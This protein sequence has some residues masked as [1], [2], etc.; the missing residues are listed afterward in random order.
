VVGKIHAVDE[1][2]LG[3]Q[4]IYIRSGNWIYCFSMDIGELYTAELGEIFGEPENSDHEEAE[5]A[6]GIQAHLGADAN[7]AIILLCKIDCIIET[8]AHFYM[9]NRSW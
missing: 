5:A 8:K 3:F 1:Y 2:E 7:F 9:R 6:E 4:I